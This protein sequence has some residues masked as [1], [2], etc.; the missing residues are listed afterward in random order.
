MA[1]TE[2]EK[3][4]QGIKDPT[5][6]KAAY[7]TR[8][9]QNASAGSATQ[10]KIQSKL[11]L[12]D[13][14]RGFAKDTLGKIMA[15]G[16][17]SIPGA[18]AE[19]A[20]SSLVPRLGEEAEEASTSMVPRRASAPPAKS[21]QHLGRATPVKKALPSNKRALGGSGKTPSV[22]SSE[23]PKV[24]SGGTKKA[25][26]TS[27][28]KDYQGELSAQTKRARIPGGKKGAVKGSRKKK[29]SAV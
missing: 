5:A 21:Y 9:R 23:T 14:I 12:G 10:K 25:L 13:E 11:G 28:E 22:G 17:F 26:T 1:M 15:S 24:L 2:D 19:E 27:G 7:Y 20:A 16:P 29:P 3:A 4:V 18:R 6:R 8:Q